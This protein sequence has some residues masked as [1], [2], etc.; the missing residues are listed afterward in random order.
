MQDKIDFGFN[1]NNVENKGV[2]NVWYRPRS[3][4]NKDNFVFVMLS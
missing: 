3:L 2:K 1:W 4:L